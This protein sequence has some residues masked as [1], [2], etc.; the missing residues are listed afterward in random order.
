MRELLFL[1]HRIPYPPDKGDKI[2]SWH[3]LKFLA[4]RYRVHLACFVDDPRDRRHQPHLES[5]CDECYF[6]PLDPLIGK[7]RGLRGLL[8]R[9]AIT[10]S[11]Y[12]DAKFRGWVDD[13]LRRRRLERI[14][15]FSSAMAPYAVDPNSDGAT[16]VIDFIDVDSDK[17]RQYAT[18][19]SRWTRWL[20]DREARLLMEFERETAAAFDASIFV[21][22]HEADLFRALAPESALKVHYLNNGVDFEHFS[23]ELL[24]ECPYPEDE[25]AIVF[26]GAMDYWPNAQAVVWFANEIFPQIRRQA[27]SAR[28]CIVGANPTANVRGLSRLSGVTVTGRVPDVR[29]YLANAHVAVAPLR[30]ARG[31]QNKVLEAMAMAKPVVATSKAVEGLDLVAGHEVAV[32][33]NAD[34]FADA[35]LALLADGAGQAL[36]FQARNRVV[37][38]YQWTAALQK[39]ENLLEIDSLTNKKIGH[40]P[41]IEKRII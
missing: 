19:K 6:A 28:F 26:T 25:K 34:N 41:N 17:W 3:I 2:R 15:V 4:E 20:Y 32:E 24:F 37:R 11:H 13:L 27:P 39:L 36:G 31:I 18:T 10:L 1:A 33:N 22:S 8:R 5:L 21:S 38:N 29:P 16:R 35:V 7:Y 9:D 40:S 14:F 23:P 12:R 30:I